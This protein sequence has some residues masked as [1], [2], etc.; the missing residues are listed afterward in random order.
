MKKLSLFIGLLFSVLL[1]AQDNFK[2]GYYID[3][4]GLK[5]EGYLRSSD[6]RTYNE[7][8][9]RNFNFK[10]DLNETTEKIDK[11]NVTEFGSESDI[12]VQKTRVRMDDGSL[13]KNYNNE[14]EFSVVERTVFLNVLVEGNANLY[15]Y[16]GGNGI[17][18]FY[19][20]NDKEEIA[21][22]L[23]YKKYYKFAQNLDENNAFRQQLYYSIKCE[24]QTFADFLNVTY[25]E[26]ELIALFTNYNKCTNAPFVVYNDKEKKSTTVNFTALLGYNVGNFRVVH[27]QHPTILESFDMFSIGAEAELVLPSERMAFFASAE[28]KNA[29]GTTERTAKVSEITDTPLRR[30]YKLDTYFLDLIAGARIYQKIA[31]S[32]SLF[33]GGGIGMNLTSGRMPTYQSSYTS[34]DLV[35]I[36]S[37]R[38][39]ASPFFTAHVGFKFKKHYGIDVNYD[40]SKQVL[41]NK[42]GD[43]IAKVHEFGVNLR[44]T[45]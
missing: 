23:L 11:M 12:K 39:G 8:S 5:K 4:Q 28:Y 20:A 18:Y 6:F 29:K 3:N 36:R 24:N 22:Q 40:S 13:F 35:K 15:S 7:D 42:S 2:K 38:L 32:S 21:K 45:F 34:T 41:G 25:D 30:L 10:K 31:N 27:I 37:E 1:F 19:K 16:D 33:L 44:Y 14:K 26:K 17:K 43:G 9:F